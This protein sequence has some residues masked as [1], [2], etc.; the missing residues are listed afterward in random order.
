MKV[1]AWVFEKVTAMVTEMASPS[2]AEMLE[3]EKAVLLVT[4]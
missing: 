2:V 4:Q 3:M 1:I